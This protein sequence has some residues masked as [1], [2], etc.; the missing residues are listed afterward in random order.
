VGVS[1]GGERN[2]NNLLWARI[3][4]SGVALSCDD[5]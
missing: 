3:R 4:I 5:F 2:Y 1:E